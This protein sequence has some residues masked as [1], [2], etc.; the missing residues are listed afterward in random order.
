VY[1]EADWF[2]RP[3]RISLSEPLQVFNE[4]NSREMEKINVFSGIFSSWI[5]SAVAGA[6]A[7]FQ[8]IIVELL[9]TFASTVHLSGRLWLASVL[10]GSVSLL[11]GAVLKLIPVGSGSDDSSS[12]DRHDGYQPIPTGPNAV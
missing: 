12:A 5:F 7:A 3:H 11:I 9:G 4:V 1:T 10:I 8:V 6:T 2:R